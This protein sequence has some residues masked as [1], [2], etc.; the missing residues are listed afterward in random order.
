MCICYTIVQISAGSRALLLLAAGGFQNFAIGNCM[1]AVM[2]C[3]R[4]L[5]LL[6]LLPLFALASLLPLGVHGAAHADGVG[7]A[8]EH[9]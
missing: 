1:G 7:I 4:L 9:M 5:S 3:Q 2:M 8:P 6:R